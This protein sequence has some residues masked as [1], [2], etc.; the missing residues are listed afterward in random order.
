MIAVLTMIF[1]SHRIVCGLVFYGV[2]FAA[3]DLGGMQYRDF[4]LASLVD[5]AGTIVCIDILKR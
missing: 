3:A 1:M 2:S 5:L 4:V